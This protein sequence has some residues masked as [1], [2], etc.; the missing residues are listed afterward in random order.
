M[1]VDLLP[2]D[3]L[4]GHLQ[5]N[6]LCFGTLPLTHDF[7]LRDTGPT[8]AYPGHSPRPWLLRAS[9]SHVACGWRLL[10]E[11]PGLAE[12][13]V[14][15]LRS[16]LP[17]LASLGRCSPPGFLAVHAG[18]YRRLPAPYP[19][20][21]GSSVSAS[22]AGWRSRW[23]SHTFASAAHRCLVDGIPRVR[24]PG[25]AVYPRFRPL[26]TSRRPGGYPDTP[27]PRGRGLHPHGKLSYKVKGL[28]F[29]SRS[30]RKPRLP[31]DQRVAP[32]RTPY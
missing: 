30:T 3:A 25:S 20:P 4:P 8:S 23:L 1:A 29:T 9:S 28:F 32:P 10:R 5:G 21:F 15:L 17:L 27:V 16:Q 11:G 31:F 26:R 22:C 19:V 14:G 12:G 2:L 24:L 13:H 18:Q 6:S 7:T